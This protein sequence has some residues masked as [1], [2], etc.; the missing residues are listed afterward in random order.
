MGAEF[1]EFDCN[2]NP[3]PFSPQKRRKW[4]GVDFRMIWPA[5]IAE[6]GAIYFPS[7]SSI[8][9]WAAASRAMGTRNGEQ[10]T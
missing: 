1:A 8:A 2:K 10:L 5:V 3:G 4:A 9:A 7:F 6:Y